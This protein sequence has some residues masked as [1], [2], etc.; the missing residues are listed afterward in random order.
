MT[1][2]KTPL[3]MG[4]IAVA[5]LSGGIFAFDNITAKEPTENK[6]VMIPF[7]NSPVEYTTYVK[8]GQ[9]VPIDFKISSTQDVNLKVKIIQIDQRGNELANS[10]KT[11]TNDLSVSIAKDSI[12][13]SGVSVSESKTLSGSVTASTSMKPGVYYMAIDTFDESTGQGWSSGFQIIVVE[14]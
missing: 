9:T 8:P 10:A 3:L 1:N 13:F 4:L 11:S 6:S 14:E 7:G 5:V 2:I 12:F